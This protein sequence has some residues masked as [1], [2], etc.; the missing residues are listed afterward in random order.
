MVANCLC[1]FL[2]FALSDFLSVASF[3]AGIK[4]SGMGKP[5]ALSLITSCTTRLRQQLCIDVS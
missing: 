4:C 1:Y 2:A 5:S 3:G